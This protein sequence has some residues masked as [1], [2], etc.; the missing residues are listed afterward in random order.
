MRLRANLPLLRWIN[1]E[2]FLIDSLVQSVRRNRLD[3]DDI[4]CFER[5]FQLVG[6]RI[7]RD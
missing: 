4:F 5:F 6:E 2:R 1:L 7:V 3:N